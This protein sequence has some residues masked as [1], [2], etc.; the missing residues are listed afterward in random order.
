MEAETYTPKTIT[1]GI[2]LSDIHNAVIVVPEMKPE[3]FN[4]FL[5]KRRSFMFAEIKKYY[6]SL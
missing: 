1:G 6:E 5:E 2:L 3:N 4:D